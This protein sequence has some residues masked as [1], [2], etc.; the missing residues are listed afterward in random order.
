MVL[1]LHIA[2]FPHYSL[3]HSPGLVLLRQITPGMASAEQPFDDR[4]LVCNP[5]GLLDNIARAR[6]AEL[7]DLQPWRYLKLTT[8]SGPNSATFL[9]KSSK[10]PR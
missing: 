6:P 8:V 1:W 3:S 9:P 10:S 4:E 7:V 2:T 5:P